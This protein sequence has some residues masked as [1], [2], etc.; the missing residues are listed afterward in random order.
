[1]IRLKL[2][3]RSFHYNSRLPRDLLEKM[4]SASNSPALKRKS[5]QSNSSSAEIPMNK[6]PGMSV[7]SMVRRFELSDGSKT[8]GAGFKSSDNDIRTAVSR[9]QCGIRPETPISSRTS[10]LSSSQGLRSPERSSQAA[11]P[12]NDATKE[13]PKNNQTKSVQKQVKKKNVSTSSLVVKKEQ[14]V[15]KARMSTSSLVSRTST[16]AQKVTTVSAFS[17]SAER[18]SF[19]RSLMCK[20]L[21]LRSRSA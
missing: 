3:S 18:Q 14:P 1:M 13:P 21:Y 4:P 7:A 15:A 16:P 8:R 2:S 9:D 11:A 20:L 5:V 6:Q 10:S 17:I 12:D 19:Y